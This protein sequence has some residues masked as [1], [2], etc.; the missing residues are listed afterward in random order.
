MY[1]LRQLTRFFAVAYKFL[2]LVMYLSIAGFTASFEDT[3]IEKPLET[4]EKLRLRLDTLGQNAPFPEFDGVV[5]HLVEE[6][7]SPRI[8]NFTKT[9]E[10]FEKKK[11]SY[12][13]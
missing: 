3:I 7:N 8:S 11:R 9:K 5:D 4:Y 13:I 6:L 1:Y 12:F 2:F 10:F